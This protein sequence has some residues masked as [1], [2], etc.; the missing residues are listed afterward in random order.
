MTIVAGLTVSLALQPV[1]HV[2]GL[3]VLAAV[4]TG[5]AAFLYRLR[6]D[7]PL[8]D[9]ATLILGLGSVALYLNT[10][11]LFVQ[12][13]QGGAG[14][15][16]AGEALLNL[17]VFVA[18]GVASYGGHRV[19]DRAARAEWV[20]W[21]RLKRDVSPIV[22]G[23]GRHISVTFPAEIEDIEGYEPVPA[24]TKTALAERTFDFPR[25]LTVDELEAQV[26][27][28][29]K[30]RFDVGYVDLELSTDGSV[31]YIGVAKRPVGIGHTVPPNE[32][33]MALRADPPFSATAGD[34]VQLWKTGGDGP[35]KVGTAELR[36]RNEDIVTIT[37]EAEVVA[38]LDPAITYRLVTL[39]V[40]PR[41]DREFAARLGWEEATMRILRI[42]EEC[43]LVGSSIAALEVITLAIRSADGTVD[44]I[45]DWSRV[46]DGGDRLYLVGRPDELRKV[47]SIPG[48]EPVDPGELDVDADIS[49]PQPPKD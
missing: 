10:R 33:A 7:H 35:T 31:S 23:V 39:P 16:S 25:G 37:A 24:E 17:G 9:G 36:A 40:G 27:T 6:V 20:S 43:P 3:V 46:L 15:P 47:E 28:R 2:V 14:T 30:E 11:S 32:A 5:T 19:G 18:A 34:T 12:F 44:P 41:L 48:I 49:S 21:R 13:V 42:D 4:V 22:R 38:D 8:P 29:L 26:T 1:L 45:P